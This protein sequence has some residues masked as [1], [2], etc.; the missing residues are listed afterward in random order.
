M[1]ALAVSVTE[2]GRQL[3]ARL[4]YEAVH[5]KATGVVR[6][7]WAA[8]DAF[9]LFLA[10][11][12]AV[13]IVAPL[14]RDKHQDPA[15]VSVDDAGR[16]AVALC[17]GHAGGANTL[18]AEVAALLEATPVLTT[19]TDATATPAL[20][21]LPGFTAAGDVAPVTTAMLDGHPP[22]IDN[23]LGWPMP[24]GLAAGRGPCR[25]TVS[26][27]AVP[28]APGQVM[29]HPPSLVVGVG[30]SS[31]AAPG[32]VAGLLVAVLADAGLAR[33]SVAEVATIDR[34]RD[35]PAV[36]ALG[37]PVKAY[38][39]GELAAVAVPWPSQA[40][41]D[42][43]GTP[44][45]AEA[46]ALLAAGRGGE[47]VVVKRKDAT[48]T[49]TVAVARRSGP[50]GCVTVV[51]LGPGHPRH[52][53][54]AAAAAVRSA[55]VVVGYGPY[56]EQAG[57]LVQAHQRVVSSPI[58]EEL[59]RAELA[60]AEAWSGRQVAV[61][62]SGDPGV[63]A[64]A[65]VLLERAER[66]APGVPVEVV[67]GVTAALAAAAVLGAPLGH[68]HAAISLSDLLTPWEVI[69]RRL[70][71]AA[72]GDFVVTLYNPASRSR[73]WQLARAS[74]V[75]LEHRKPGTPV[76]VVTDVSRAGQSVHLT[77]LGELDP[78]GVDMR[79]TVVVGSTTTTVVGG[80]MVTPRGYDT[81]RAG[82]E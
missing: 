33:A 74:E 14:L 21:S 80:R 78:A 38:A 45:V 63:Y 28:A 29:L 42:A 7:R 65:S 9:V 69:E 49:A 44:S 24:P 60:L 73:T 18:T 40:V 1:R 52:R 46:A 25:V 57:D 34:R 50:R 79:T 59:G 81:A 36:V 23:E 70:R 32:D 53:T 5:G 13:R 12:A 3:A 43:V 75:L 56:V 4:P 58:G 15:V 64:M 16:F 82:S 2:A 76:G 6:A 35:H 54:P 19:A 72:E 27:R 48:G 26:D 8:F 68:D 37:L 67:P 30:T 11:G 51:G 31:Q 77:T 61:V 10:T 41:F 17:G 47:L 71:A 39:P 55:D 66:L 22:A 62:C 20:D